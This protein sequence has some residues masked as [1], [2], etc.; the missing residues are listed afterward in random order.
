MLFHLLCGIPGSG[1]ST[2]SKKIQGYV[3]STDAIRKFLWNDAS[4]VKHDP[5]VFEV[6]ESIIRYMLSKAD[7][8]FDA[9]NLKRETRCKYIGL[10][11]ELGAYVTVHWVNCPIKIA[12]KRNAERTRKVPIAV[13]KAFGKSLHMPSMAEG[14]D[15]IV[16]YREDLTVEEEIVIY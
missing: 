8:I 12:L 15:K 7:V 9:T 16:F 13:I 10:A 5:L 2:L 14:M 3:V 4:I 6:A 11:K 1:K